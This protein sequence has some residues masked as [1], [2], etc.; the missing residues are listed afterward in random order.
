[1]TRIWLALTLGL[2]AL[3]TPLRSQAPLP[4]LQAQDMQYQGTFRLPQAW[5]DFNFGQRVM[6]AYY[7]AHGSLIVCGSGLPNGYPALCGEISIPTD[8]S[9]MPFATQLQASSDPFDGRV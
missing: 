7:A 9:T 4:L 2:L 6:P 8:L 3:A 1:M 5:T